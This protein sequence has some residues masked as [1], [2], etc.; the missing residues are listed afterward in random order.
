[1]QL[2]SFIREIPDFPE[3]GILFRDITPMLQDVGAFASAVDQLCDHFDSANFDIVVPVESRGF[4]FGMLLAQRLG[5]GFVPIRKLG[6]LPGKV[7]SENYN[8]EY[9]TDALEIQENAIASGEKVLIHD[10]VLATGGT[11]KAACNLIERLNAEVVAV[12]FL[13]ELTFLEGATPLEAYKIHS[14]FKY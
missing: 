5:V 6:K 8:L 11:A 3:P 14:I 7:L 1:M 2:K 4:L 9:G 13:I 12:N 10:D